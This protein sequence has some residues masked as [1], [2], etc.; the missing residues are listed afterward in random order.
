MTSQ[1]D[2]E[3]PTIVQEWLRPIALHC[4]PLDVDVYV[5]RI[6]MKFSYGIPRAPSIIVLLIRDDVPPAQSAVLQFQTGL[7]A[8]GYYP[9]ALSESPLR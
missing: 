3:A 7:K 8:R 6:P 2:G 5:L 9:R 4:Q 1:L